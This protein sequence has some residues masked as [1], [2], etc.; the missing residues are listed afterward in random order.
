MT[1]VA[2]TA[3]N[4]LSLYLLW[5]KAIRTDLSVKEDIKRCYM[6]IWKLFYLLYFFVPF[7]RFTI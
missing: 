1:R 5:A 7:L 2:F 4:G 6:F 3:G